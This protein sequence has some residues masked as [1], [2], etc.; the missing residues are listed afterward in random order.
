VVSGQTTNV[1]AVYYDEPFATAVRTIT[2]WTNVSLA[3]TCPLGVSAWTLIEQIPA[4]VTPTLYPPGTWNATARTLTYTG[5]VSSTIGYTALLAVAG[6]NDLTNSIITSITNNIT[7]PVTG[8]YRV[9]R[10]DFLRKISGTNVWIY[11]FAPTNSRPWT[12]GE[13]L[14]D[15]HLEAFNWSAGGDSVGGYIYWSGPTNAA[16]HVLSY[17]VRGPAGYTNIINGD[18]S[19]TRPNAY[20]TIYGD[21]TVIIPAPLPD[22][23]SVVVPPPTILRF[24]WNGTTASL[25]FTSI[26][27]QAYSVL[28]NANMLVT[29]GWRNCIPAIAGEAGTTTVTVPVVEPRLFYRVKS[30]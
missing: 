21:D 13:N 20:Y 3:V 17:S 29:N 8:D 19:L 4:N 15:T 5:T 14:N 12:V 10:G 26:V 25:T 23:P 9:S 27:A 22:P 6:D 30:D 11:M 7:K 28:T 24:V 1:V 16:G 2:S 18:V